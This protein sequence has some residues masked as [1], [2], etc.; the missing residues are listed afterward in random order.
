[1]CCVTFLKLKKKIKEVKNRF[2]LAKFI[3]SQIAN[4]IQ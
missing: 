1:M 4:A 3:D 2:F